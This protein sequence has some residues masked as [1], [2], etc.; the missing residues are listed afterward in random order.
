TDAIRISAAVVNVNETD[1]DPTNDTFFESTSVVRRVDLKVSKIGSIDP[2]VAG[3]G[4][5]NLIYTVTVTNQGYSDA[6]AVALS[7]ALTLP[8]GVTVDTITG[9]AGTSYAGSVWTV[10]TLAANGSAT[11]TVKLTADHTTADGAIISDTATVT[12]VAEIDTVAGNN[13]ATLS[14]SVVRRV[15]LKVSKIGS[16]DPVVAGSGVDN[17]IY[18]VTVNNQGFSD[19]WAV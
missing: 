6:S 1:T 2:V 19:A 18:T 7:E 5:D 8:A 16:I 9:S 4:V 12:N 17:L 15:D 13:Q 3:S 14:T 10:G 11:L